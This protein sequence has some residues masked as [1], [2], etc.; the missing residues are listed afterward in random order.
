MTGLAPMDAED[1]LRGHA[2]AVV[3]RAHGAAQ[4][5]GGKHVGDSHDG[6]P[7]HVRVELDLPSNLDK[8]AAGWLADHPFPCVQSCEV[9]GDRA[10]MVLDLSLEAPAPVVAPPANTPPANT[11]LDAEPRAVGGAASG[12]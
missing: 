7:T 4:K 12:S 11:G 1:R 2:A 3:R 10:V 5:G 6:L 9:D 8:E